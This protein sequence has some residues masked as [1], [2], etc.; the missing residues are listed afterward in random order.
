M[1]H[2]PHGGAGAAGVGGALLGGLG[3][4]DGSL[5]I[6]GGF[7]L[8][9]GDGVGMAG[10]QAVAQTVAVM[11]VHQLRLAVHQADGPLVAGVDAGPAAVAL[12]LVDMDDLADHGHD[13]LVGF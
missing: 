5:V 9:K 3:R 11:L 13:L 8:L 10:G 2:L 12:F 7:P 1:L 4:Q 6:G